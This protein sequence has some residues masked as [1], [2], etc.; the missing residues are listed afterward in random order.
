MRWFR[1]RGEDGPLRRLVVVSDLHGSTQCLRK[2][3][4]AAERY[5][6][7]AILVAGDLTGKL[8][9]PFVRANGGYRYMRGGTEL[10]VDASVL[11]EHLA[12]VENGG[13]YPYVTT[14]EELAGLEDDPDA[15]D[16]IFHELVL[17]RVEQWLELLEH[18][19]AAAG[20]TMLII[21]G[22]DD[23]PEIDG[24]L[25]RG[26]RVRM[27][28]QRVVTLFGEHEVVG[29]GASNK[30]PWHAPRDLSEEAL[31]ERLDALCAQLSDPQRAIFLVHCPPVRT[32]IDLAPE[33][34]DELRPNASGAM[35]HVGSSAV[36]TAIEEVQPLLGVHGHIH[37]APGIEQLG[38]TTVVNP[39]SE[40]G[41]G[42]LRG[43]FVT[44]T[45]DRVA[46]HMFFSG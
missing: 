5:E 9:V 23:F 3:L 32:R 18:R 37:E 4:A 20:R 44:L 30:T 16:R 25:E 33:I 26:E 17:E 15:V 24:V 12:E 41:Q 2:T 1:G 40:Y 7:E 27:A 34:D 8:V 21:P 6:A 45:G 28:D 38:R 43:V 36:R 14:P 42:I 22:N 13:L 11:Q 35:A 10:H 46:G 29:M 19:L 39:G 31:A